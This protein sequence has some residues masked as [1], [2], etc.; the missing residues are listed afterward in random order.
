METALFYMSNGKN[1][2]NL[3]D[4]G[5]IKPSH[6]INRDATVNQHTSNPTQRRKQNRPHVTIGRFF[7]ILANAMSPGR[8][9][10]LPGPAKQFILNPPSRSSQ[11]ALGKEFR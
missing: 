10:A 8:P 2:A 11:Q 3:E 7:F 6:L 1:T 9:V 4:S 5:K